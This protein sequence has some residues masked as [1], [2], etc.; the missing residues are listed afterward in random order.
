MTRELTPLEV[1]QVAAEMERNAARFYRRAAGMYHDPRLSKL[2]SELAQWEKRHVQVFV[3][4]KDRFSEQTWEGRRFD[5]ERREG[6]R[7]EVPPAVFH[8]RSEPAKELT[9]S[10]T[11]ADVI[12]LAIQKERHSIGYY[13]ALT[14]FALGRDNIQA[15]K[16]ILEEERRHLRI[17]KQSLQQASG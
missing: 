1:L 13:L 7:L 17:L 3:D 14:E 2:F 12:K 11:R 15:I 6:S 10:E 8:E 9:G 4:M 5:L 16:A